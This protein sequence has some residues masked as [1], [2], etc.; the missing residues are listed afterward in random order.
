M[1]DALV[2]QS[3]TSNGLSGWLQLHTNW[4][5]FYDFFSD[6]LGPVGWWVVLQFVIL[7]LGTRKGLRL[8]WLLFT[9]TVTNTLLK[10][11]WAEPRPYWADESVNPLRA[12]AGFGMPSGHA[13]GAT[14]LWLGLWLLL[15]GRA[16]LALVIAFIIF[17]GLSRIYYGV[18]S[19]AQVLVGTGFGVALSLLVWQ[20]LPGLEARLRA[21]TLNSRVA[22]SIATVAI[23]GVIC[24]LV[25]AFRQDFVAPAEWVVRFEAAQERFGQTGTMGL[26]ESGSL[27]LVAMLAGYVFLALVASAKGHRAL[28]LTQGRMTRFIVAI[29]TAIVLNIAALLALRALHADAWL[30]GIWLCVQPLVALWLPLYWFG[31]TE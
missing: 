10:W 8:A 14:A 5:A 25:F 29:V 3:A 30:A 23:V 21:M 28:V 2:G 24:W 18:H 9:A 4:P 7:L 19:T 16:L 26:V 20:L 31:E 13:Q 22:T 27:L 1:S 11:L 12:T 17:T 15:R 6:V